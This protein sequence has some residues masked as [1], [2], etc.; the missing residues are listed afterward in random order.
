MCHLIA[1][2]SDITFFVKLFCY[3][4]RYASKFTPPIKGYKVPRHFEM[5]PLSYLAS[6]FSIPVNLDWPRT[7]LLSL[8]LWAENKRGQISLSE[9]TND[10]YHNHVVGQDNVSELKWCQNWKVSE[11][12]K[13]QS[14]KSFRIGKCERWKG[15]ELESVRIRKCKF[16]QK[17][18]ISL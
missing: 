1:Y 5:T 4:S 2:L 13:Y 6:L 8:D 14:W 3:E 11:L 10:F 9:T 7:E 17:R 15:L 12:K 18:N 16:F